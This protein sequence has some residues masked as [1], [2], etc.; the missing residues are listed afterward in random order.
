MS[1]WG[2]LTPSFV[3]ILTSQNIHSRIFCHWYP[4]DFFFGMG[5]T[6]TLSLSDGTT[7]TEAQKIGNDTVDHFAKKIP[8]E[9]A[10]PKHQR[11]AVEAATNSLFVIAAWIGVATEFA[12]NFPVPLHLITLENK[13]KFAR[14]STASDRPPARTTRRASKRK[15]EE[16]LHQRHPGDL[17]ACPRWAQLR[18]RIVA[19]SSTAASH[20]GCAGRSG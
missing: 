19:K 13:S 2:T 8:K 5:D 15:R 11:E 7:L 18:S 4:M 17:S 20:S 10:P 16:L 12:N 9:N 6:E 14:D 3:S 1:G